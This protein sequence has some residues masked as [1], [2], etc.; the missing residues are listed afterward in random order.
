MLERWFADPAVAV[1][2]M[3]AIPMKR[4]AEPEEVARVALFLASTDASFITG[5]A[6]AVEGGA[7]AQ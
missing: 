3:G 4:V 7:L 2:V 1:R 5:H 6:L